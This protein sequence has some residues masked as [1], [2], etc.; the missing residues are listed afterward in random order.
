MKKLLWKLLE[1]VDNNHGYSTPLQ[2]RFEI[3][4]GL[5]IS[6]DKCNDTP[7]ITGEFIVILETGRHD[8]LVKNSEGVKHCVYQFEL[9]K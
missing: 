6:S 5:R 3:G 9:M 1:M 7:Y 2:K 8:Y 4:E